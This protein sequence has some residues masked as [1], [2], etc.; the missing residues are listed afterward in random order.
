MHSDQASR[1]IQDGNPIPKS[2]DERSPASTGPIPLDEY[3]PTR[4]VVVVVIAILLALFLNALD[5]TIVAT[6]I[7]AI[8][9][10]FDSLQDIGWYG[11]AY[12]LTASCLQ[13]LFGR[14]YTFYTPKY[15]FLTLIGLFE[16]GSAICGAA[17]NSVAF[18]VGRAIAGMGSAGITSGGV[19]LMLSIIPLAK[20]PKYQ[21]LY[22]AVFGLASVIGPLLGGAFTTK[23]SWRWCFYINLPIGGLA[24]FII[25]LILKPAPPQFQRLTFKQKVTRL[26]MLGELF[27]VPCVICLLLA[28][29]W[30][31]STYSWSDGRIIALLVVFGVLFLAFVL[32]Q[33]LMQSSGTLPLSVISNRSIIAG[34]M[35]NFCFSSAM[36][37]LVYWIPT[38]FQAI[39]GTSPV[40]SGIDTIPLVLSLV[41]ASI[42]AGQ[43]VGRIGYYTPFAM[44][45]AIIMPIGAGLISTWT[46]H[47]GSP[48]WIGFQVLFGFG[49]GLGMQ[50]ATMAAQT[51]LRKQDVPTGVAL[52]FF[53]QQLG[54]AI[55]V[56]VGQYVLN[57]KLV[58]GIVRLVPDLSPERILNTGATKLRRIVPAQ[59]LQGVLVAYNSALRQVFVVATA[60]ACL[61][62]LGA[63]SLEW[64][65]VKAK[66]GSGGKLTH[67]AS[68]TG[69]KTVSGNEA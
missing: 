33:C 49:V 62:A 57:S 10:E 43:A 64:R 15:V 60:M 22:G 20:R 7:P 13:L 25:L 38:W 4:E 44:A 66:E 19:I 2:K 63:F 39:K 27:L 35:F 53:A 32:V 5:R 28:L 67:G 24:M 8:T 14:I 21:G 54:G 17:P 45:S 61:A 58:S 6:A 56:S 50:Q 42:L 11:S 55:F 48:K 46:V 30:G 65:S 59:D 36:M 16:V 1:E 51:V 69:R 47:T 68:E 37:A 40:E 9:N 3:P 12:M 52:L 31:G 23:V 34:I 18:I 29:Q 41:V 26:D